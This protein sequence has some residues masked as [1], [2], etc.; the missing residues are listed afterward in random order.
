VVRDGKRVLFVPAEWVAG[1]DQDGLRL[2]ATRE[3]LGGIVGSPGGP[4]L[5]GRGQGDETG[6]KKAA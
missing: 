2:S 5:A 1:F 6:G 3:Q 4:Y